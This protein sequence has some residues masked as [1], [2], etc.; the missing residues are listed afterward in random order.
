MWLIFLCESE[1]VD[2]CGKAKRRPH[3][4][5]HQSLVRHQI[6]ERHCGSKEIGLGIHKLR[7]RKVTHL[8]ANQPPP[9]NFT[10]YKRSIS[11]TESV[12]GVYPPS[13]RAPS[14]RPTAHLTDSRRSLS[15]AENGNITIP[16]LRP[17]NVPF[18]RQ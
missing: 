3:V 9:F 15:G 14:A 8:K 1:K 7:A 12:Q 17:V 11:N 2:G 13:S 6:R 16:L 10:I 4:A 5:V 18:E